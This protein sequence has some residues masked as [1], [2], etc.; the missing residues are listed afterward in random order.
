MNRVF[1]PPQVYKSGQPSLRAN[2]IKKSET[3]RVSYNTCKKPKE[4]FLFT[5]FKEKQTLL[6]KTDLNLKKHQS[7]DSKPTTESETQNMEQK[8]LG[9]EE[10]MDQ[11][12][13]TKRKLKI[14]FQIRKGPKSP[15]RRIS[16]PRK[17]LPECFLDYT[18][19]KQ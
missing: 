8:I 5:F 14:E 17:I 10:K 13:S 1:L 2:P 4:E 9:F 3:V 16:S 12:I 6:D 19:P 11:Q 15:Q 18:T 7:L